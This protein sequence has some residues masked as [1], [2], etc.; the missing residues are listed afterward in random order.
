MFDKLANGIPL[1]E[2]AAFFIQ[3]RTFEKTAEEG[4]VGSSSYE[5]PDQTGRLE[6]Q[7]E[8]PVEVV[9]QQMAKMVQNELKTNFAYMVY[10]NSLRDLSHPGIAEEFEDHATNETEHADWL[11]RRMSV[12]G[13]P[14]QI[15]DIPS[16]PPSSDPHDIIQRMIRI[17]Q[18]GI[19]NW[20]IL[21][22]LVGDENPMKFKIEEYLTREQEHLDE[23]WQL[24][25]HQANP[26][27]LLRQQAGGMSSVEVPT[28]P[29][30]M[31]DTSPAP[32]EGLGKTAVSEKW[33]RTLTQRG[34]HPLK[35]SDG[36][37]EGFAD[38]AYAA[39][40]AVSDKLREAVKKLPR[41][42]VPPSVAAEH[43]K[44][45][46]RLGKQ[47]RNRNAA[48]NAADMELW[49]RG[50]DKTGS[51][52]TTAGREQIA[53]KN[54]ALSAKQSD[55]GKPAYPI[56]DKAHAANALARVKQHGTPAEKAEV[57]KDVARKFPE[58]AARSSVPS[59]QA[60][61]KE[62]NSQMPGGLPPAGMG[63]H[64]MASAPMPLSGPAA[65]DTGM[66]MAMAFLKMAKEERSPE[67]VGK[68]R[69]RASLSA[70]F[71]KEKAHKHERNMDMAGRIVG[72]ASGGAAMHRYGKGNALATLGGI[73]LGQHLGGKALG[74]L[75]YQRDMKEHEKSAEAFKLALE[76]LSA[77][78]G[79]PSLAES[80]GE[81][82]ESPEE[83]MPM[84]DPAVMQYLQQEQAG[85]AAEKEQESNFYRQKFQEASQQ[86]QAANQQMQQLQQQAD[87]TGQQQ[88]QAMQQAQ[89]IQQAAMQ[90]AQAA[91]QA[92]TQAMQQ[93]LASQQQEMQ[94]AQLAVGMRDAV[95]SM[96][97]GLMQMVQ[98]QLPPAT[99]AEAGTAPQGAPPAPGGMPGMDN[100]Q[101]A[102]N[103]EQAASNQAGQPQAQ[104]DA[105]TPMQSATPGDGS[106]PGANPNMGQGAEPTMQGAQPQGEQ[107]MAQQP[108]KVASS[109][110]KLIG[111]IVGGLAGGGL[112]AYGSGSRAAGANEA[113]R[114]KIQ[115]MEEAD[116]GGGG[117]MNA[118][119]LAQAK[120][121]LAV[122]E[123][124]E[125]HPVAST[126]IG[127]G[128]G[129]SSLSQAAP[130]LRR[131]GSDIRKVIGG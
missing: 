33:V 27:V 111:A 39:R 102:P 131:A 63:Q 113:L 32:P 40:D 114:Q 117:F 11:L 92:A 1:H 23:L 44:T 53:N 97:Q 9:L 36:A 115:G 96:R 73:A 45:L 35:V 124:E 7:F 105:G 51:D 61:V 107:G 16:P 38:R 8:A 130:H 62:K 47:L 116:R 31:P 103:A 106:G 21:R 123:F 86:L 13:G 76:S 79:A 43:E 80:S 37:V 60:K 71:E 65:G 87:S 77:T 93:S 6:G 82:V 50:L 67:E 20:R 10:S 18:E 22:K 98:Q 55:T 119:N 95:H 91:H 12:L 120:A 109:H 72:G 101:Q 127:A 75:G 108:Q 4:N 52:L 64:S 19:N 54:F 70:E 89:Q 121:R 129:A 122:G 84:Q 66:K 15:P 26:E 85:M 58:L 3:L 128:L 56:H 81:A 41:G 46:D 88:Q 57:Y 24:L 28:P 5:P 34:S 78:G 48:Y 90:N 83:Q 126:A 118:M 49:K 125:R 2:A 74:H 104:P 30:S 59:V 110:D 17:E 68:E 29:P 42:A 94:Q 112:A 99:P 69:A 100:S 14:V 25:P